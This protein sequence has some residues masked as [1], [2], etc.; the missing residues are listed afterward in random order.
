[1][2][3]KMNLNATR[4]A[5]A[6]DLHE[7]S[8]AW[9]NLYDRVELGQIRNERQYKSLV[10][11]ADRLIDEIGVNQKHALSSF[12]EVIMTLIEQYEN[13]VAPMEETE[14]RLVL[15][16][17]MEQHDVKQ[18]EL[19]VEIGTQG[20]VSEILNGKREINVRQAKALAHRFSVSPAVFL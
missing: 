6:R 19:R 15:A 10:S 18:S 7:I 17:L 4:S 9:S 20:V 16:F 12:L 2:E 14:P 13:V 5:P 1:M 3:T 8:S 11:L